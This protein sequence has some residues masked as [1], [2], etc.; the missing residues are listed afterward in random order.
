MRWLLF[1]SRVA[2][3]TGIFFILSVSL[4]IRDWTGDDA[5]TS[6]IITIG[7]TLGLVVV[8]IVNLCYLLVLIVKRRLREIVPGWLI[9]AN[10]LFLCILIAYILFIN[11]Y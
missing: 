1:L 4:L 6:T 5:V 3:I 10:F 7:F 11:I 8:P 9:I 2:F